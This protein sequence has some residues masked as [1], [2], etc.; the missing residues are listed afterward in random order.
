MVTATVIVSAVLALGATDAVARVRAQA[1]PPPGTEADGKV[2]EV[3]TGVATM[4]ALL[5]TGTVT[6]DRG[7]YVL[8][9]P[10][11]VLPGATLQ[12]SG[13]SL[14]LQAGPE[15]ASI[16]V[17]GTL[18]VTNARISGGSGPRAALAEIVVREQG[19][20]ALASS[21][22]DRLGASE[23]HAGITVKSGAR[24]TISD[25]TIERNVHGVSAIDA[26][27]VSVRGA[28]ISHNLGSGVVVHGSCES[29]TVRDTDVTGNQADG[30][31]FDTTC[32]SLSILGGS[33][34]RNGGSG[35]DAAGSTNVQI[36]GLR[37]WGNGSGVTTQDAAV[38]DVSG[39]TLSANREDG[40]TMN[41]PSG[42]LRVT[43]SRI[44]H[45]IRSGISVSSGTTTVGPANTIAAN[46]V[47]VRL[48]TG[49]SSVSAAGNAVEH[50]VRDGFSLATLTGITIQ[51]NRIVDNGDA[52]FSVARTGDAEPFL[53]INT[54]SASS[55]TERTRA[56]DSSDG[57]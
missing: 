38:V 6:R 23:N 48:V 54:V 29:F 49:A 14:R 56:E 50:N 45:N 42:T 4:A 7:T 2:V 26:G 21:S 35:L 57:Q 8:H 9:Q 51:D 10:V 41:A 52:A 32:A 16:L 27:R 31:S 53:G 47:G 24:A 3:R 18:E 1:V 33:A 13:E 37:S 19:A 44:D 5:E 39:A 55:A 34:N 36:V 22:V 17:G 12:L 40:I 28:T 20:L 46:D 25:T 11:N 15:P 30:Y 43:R